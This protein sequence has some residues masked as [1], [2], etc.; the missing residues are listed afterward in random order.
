MRF[1]ILGPLEV[2]ADGRPLALGGARARDVLATML[3]HANQVVSAD[4]VVDELW[5]KQPAERAAA[6]LQVRL[7]GLRRALRSAG[8]NTERLVTLP[9][10]YL[11]R[12]EPGEL[13]AGRFE[14]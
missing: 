13:D 7:S 2:T 11:L 14:Q 3:V 10:G 1:G 4:Q 5:P 9:P 12:V 6:S 8:E